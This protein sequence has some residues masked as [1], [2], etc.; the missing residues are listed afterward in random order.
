MDELFPVSVAMLLTATIA[1]CCPTIR[2]LAPG[3][4]SAARCQLLLFGVASTTTALPAGR[5]SGCAGGAGV[6][7][8]KWVKAVVGRPRYERVRRHR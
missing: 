6:R 2:W 5:A 3:R 1:R 8:L 4:A 7:G